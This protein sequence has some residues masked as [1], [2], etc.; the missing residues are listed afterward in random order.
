MGNRQGPR[1]KGDTVEL[2]E[3]TVSGAWEMTPRLI[4]DR[5]G[6]FLEVFKE[7]TF[8]EATGRPFSLKQ[9]NSSISAAGVVRGIHVA[10]VPPG[11]AKYVVCP[12][13]AVLDYVVDVRVGSPTFGEWDTVLLDDV[14]RRAVFVSEG[15]GHMFLSLE[16]DSTVV[17]LCSEPFTMV[18]EFG[19]NPMCD[20]LRIDFPSEA[21]DGSPLELL[22]SEKDVA[23]PGLLE[24]R[25][26][27]I[28]PT[29]EEQQVF[30]N[31]LR[32]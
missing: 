32:A 16:A 26:L 28:L 25:D 3:L 8:V 29:F 2:R 7:E 21:R 6:V 27:G 24:A 14:D 15:L 23:A 10:Q 20:E 17:Y 18:R 30:V 9:A 19:I 13:G 12:K 22:R 11:Q 5:R 4:E 31:S 1:G